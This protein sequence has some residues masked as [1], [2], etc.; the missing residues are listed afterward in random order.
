MRKPTCFHFLLTA[1]ALA[2]LPLLAVSAHATIGD[3]YET[4]NG[5]VI[6]IRVGGGTP[7]TFATG[8]ANPKGLVFDGT[9]R[10]F[11]ADASAGTLVVFDGGGEGNTYATNLSSPVGVTFDPMG[12][13]YVGEAGNGR[14]TKIAVDGDRST[15]ASGLGSPAGIA[16]ATNGNLFVADFTGGIIYQVTP[17]GTETTFATGLDFPAGLAFDTAG[18]LFVA[19]S[20]SGSIFKFTPDGTRSTFATGLS[21]PYGLAF[22]SSG[23]LV[24]SDNGNG[25]TFRFTPDGVRSTIFSSDFNTPQF[26]AIEPAT[27]QLLNMS[28]RGFVEGGDHILVAGFIIGGIGPVGTTVVV[29]ATGPS[30]AAAGVADPLPNPLL[31]IRDANGALIAF[32]DN[33]RDAPL[34]QRVSGILEPT[35]D[36]E[37]ALQL[38]LGGGSYTAIVTSSDGATGTAIVEVYNLQ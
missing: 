8:L 25:S 31:G 1:A 34:A 26:V 17:T 5:T 9:G 38:V 6:R 11:V 19:D 24:V 20:E 36:M 23:T 30:L 13:L 7:N 16:F 22:E 14:I 12:N 18:N 15:F 35:N 32:N 10:L 3:I 29:R 33:W 28:T 27:H 4:N 21:R 2:L 37:S